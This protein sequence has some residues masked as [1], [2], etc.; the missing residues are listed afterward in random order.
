MAQEPYLFRGSLS[1]NTIHFP[2]HN[3]QLSL[4]PGAAPTEDIELPHP[5]GLAQCLAFNRSLIYVERNNS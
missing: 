1:F 3:T 5:G 2:S 4:Y